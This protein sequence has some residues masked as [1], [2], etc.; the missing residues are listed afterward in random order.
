MF[1]PEHAE[2]ITNFDTLLVISSRIKPDI[3]TNIDGLI[4][5]CKLNLPDCKK[6]KEL[7]ELKYLKTLPDYEEIIYENKEG[8][9]LGQM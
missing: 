4:Q 1:L 3:V 5:K 7:T 8:E 9:Y 2:F 6:V